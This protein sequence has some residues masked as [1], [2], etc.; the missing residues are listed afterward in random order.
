MVI[1]T[2][3]TIFFGALRKC[4]KITVPH[5]NFYLELRFFEGLFLR[6]LI[7]EIIAGV[8]IDVKIDQQ[9]FVN[10]HVVLYFFEPTEGCV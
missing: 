6:V 4:Y 8:K 9:L 7:M 5:S 1:F 10:F 3:R 2:V